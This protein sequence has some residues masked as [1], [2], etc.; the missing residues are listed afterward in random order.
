LQTLQ[1]SQLSVPQFL[2]QFP[3][4][5]CRLVLPKE[6][7]SLMAPPLIPLLPQIARECHR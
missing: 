4:E 2:I 6:A 3:K 7:T 1:A 5:E